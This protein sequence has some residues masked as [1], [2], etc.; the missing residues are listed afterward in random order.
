MA[1][2]T[3]LPGRVHA[4]RLRP[5]PRGR[6]KGSDLLRRPELRAP[7][8]EALDGVEP[9]GA[10]SATASSCARRPARRRR[11][12]RRRCSRSSA[13]ALG[14]DG[15][16]VLVGGNHDHGAGRAVDRRPPAVRAARLLGARAAHA[17]PRRR[18]ARRPPR[19]ARRARRASRVAYPGCGCATTSTPS[20]GTTSTSTPRSRPSSAWPPAR[21]RAGSSHLPERRRDRRRL[22]GRAGAVVRV[23]A[24]A[25]PALRNGA[26]TGGAG[27]SARAWVALAGDGRRAHRCAPPRSAPATRRRRRRS[28][29]P[30][31]A[32]SSA[33][34]PARRCAAAASA[35]MGEVLRRLGVD[36]PSTSSSATRHRSGPWPGDDAAEWRRAGRRRAAQ[37]RQLGAT[38]RTSSPPSRAASPYWPG[39]GGPRGRER[40]AR[41]M[42]LLG[43]RGHDRAAPAATAAP[44]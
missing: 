27:A 12:R 33:T 40:P 6:M 41:L 16:I 37:H 30:A 2:E 31:S 25:R 26:M 14:P 28:T 7:L 23:D 9:P 38:S 24:H 32:R 22:R 4:R 15:E 19:G 13:R 11:A 29:R 20:T 42:R 18:P 39:H 10:S 21:W 44:A 8:L 43:D 1:R 3:S 17:R 5:A 36:A 34:C 35:A